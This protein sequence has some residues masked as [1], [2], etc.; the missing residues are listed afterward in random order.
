MNIT[1]KIKIICEESYAET[2]WCKQLMNGLTKEL[3]KRR[4]AYEQQYYAKNI[5]EEDCICLLG[6]SNEWIGS[7]VRICNESGCVPIVL[8][9]QSKCNAKGQYHLICP[10]IQ[11][12]IAVLK[13]SAIRTKPINPN[14]PKK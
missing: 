13:N 14:D 1:N 3:K 6:M 10:D 5:K 4:F 8:S 12:S 9:N 2:I 11:S 7:N